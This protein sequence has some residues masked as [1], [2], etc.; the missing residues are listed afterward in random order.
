MITEKLAK[1]LI[2]QAEYNCSKEKVNYKIDEIIPLSEGGAY[3]IKASSKF[4]HTSFVAY[5]D[6]TA[7]FLDD[8]QDSYPANE[9][10]ICLYTNWVTIDWQRTPVIFLG[11]PRVL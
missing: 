7:Y 3:L 2:E 5:E 9:D 11:L 8:W 6:G 10:E 4:C 1:Q